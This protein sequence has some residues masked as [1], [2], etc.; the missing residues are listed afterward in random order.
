MAR[1][2][3]WAL[4]ASWSWGLGAWRPWRAMGR[5]IRAR[6]ASFG[7]GLAGDFF[8]FEVALECI[9]VC[10]DDTI[11]CVNG[12]RE[13]SFNLADVAP[14][15]HPSCSTDATRPNGYA[16][17]NSGG[18]IVEAG[19]TRRPLLYISPGHQ[20]VNSWLRVHYRYLDLSTVAAANKRCKLVQHC[21]LQLTIAL[22]GSRGLL[23]SSPVGNE[24]RRRALLIC[25][26]SSAS[27]GKER[28][29]CL[30]T[31]KL[32]RAYDHAVN[33]TTRALAV[34]RGGHTF[35]SPL[36]Q[37]GAIAGVSCRSR[38]HLRP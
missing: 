25:P 15:P 7:S 34:T 27:R 4:A 17:N 10:V 11:R 13:G 16:R 21:S 33:C 9:Y 8:F 28:L 35:G 18:G 24:S 36:T 19:G 14:E 30:Q 32:T 23:L 29:L 3:P 37:C 2:W 20:A 1:A 5:R 22:F 31:H 6:R 26:P 38:S 12:V